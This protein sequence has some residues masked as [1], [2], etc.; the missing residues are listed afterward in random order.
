[1][2][3]FVD[4]VKFKEVDNDQD[5]TDKLWALESAYECARSNLDCVTVATDASVCTDHTIQA[6]AAVF[7]LH[8]DELLWWFHCAVGKATTPDAELFALQLGVEHACCVPNAKLIVLFTDHITAVQSAVDPSTH[9]GQAH[10]LA[11]CGCLMEWLGADAEHTIEFHEVRSHLKWPF[12]Q[13]VH[14]YATDPSF[15]VSM[16]AHPSTTLGYLHKAKVE[17]CKDEWTRLFALPTYAGKDFL[18]LCKGDDK[19][20]QPT[21]LHGGV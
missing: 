5:D 12:H 15:Q 14:A 2:D 11:V 16:G 10:S 7:L 13:S 19:F 1:M 4:R 9:S 6:V 3:C 18:R 8:R 17:A 21:Y 20:I